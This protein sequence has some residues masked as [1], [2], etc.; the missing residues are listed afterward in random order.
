MAFFDRLIGDPAMQASLRQRA[1]GQGTMAAQTFAQ[2][3][4]ANAGTAAG[5]QARLADR[6]AASPALAGRIAS[7]QQATMNAASGAQF[8]TQQAAERQRAEQQLAE[9]RVQRQSFFRQMIGGGLRTA[10]ALGQTLG[11][12]D[13]QSAQQPAQGG[14]AGMAGT[15]GGVAGTAVGGPL[16]GAVGSVVGQQV[17]GGFV[18]PSAAAP[19][20]A[21]TTALVDQAIGGMP[22]GQAPVIPPQGMMT[23]ASGLTDE[24][25]IQWLMSQRGGA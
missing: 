13:P 5:T 15:L 7:Q 25:Y 4:A 20:G 11:I 17:L 22:V 14:G 8:A 16:G 24:E 10:G 12:G 21:S 3:R 18:P 9:M 6:G 1:Q 19:A 2:Q 23:D